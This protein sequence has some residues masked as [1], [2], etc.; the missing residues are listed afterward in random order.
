MQ[1]QTLNDLNKPRV[2]FGKKI[3]YAVGGA[4]DTLAY[5]FVAAFLLFFLTDFAGVNPAWAGAILTIGVIWD[6]IT[7]PIIGNLSDKTKTKFGRKRTWLIIAIVPLFVS[8][9][10]LFTKIDVMSEG[11]RN[12]YFLGMTLLFWLSYTFFSIPYYAIGASMTTDNT[13]RT[14]IRML[15]MIIQYIGVFFST[16]A[17][18]MFVSFFKAGGMDSYHAWHYTAWINACICVVSLIIVVIATKD[19]EID[20]EPE[21]EEKEKKSNLIKDCIAILKIKPYLISML[22]S[23]M[24]R[25]G[26]CFFLTTMT[27]FLLYVVALTEMKMTACTSIISFGGIIV[28][29]IL[30]KV[31]EKID[32]VKVY[33]VLLL[34]SGAGMVLFNFLDVNTMAMACLMACIYVVGSSAYWAINIP[35]M[36]DSIEVDEF[37]SGIR[38]EGTMMSFYLCCQKAGYAIAASIIGAVLTNS[39]YDETLGANNPQH[40]LDAIQNMTCLA[41]GIFFI[42]AAAIMFIYPLKQGVYDKL[43][44]QLENKRAGKEYNTEGFAHV[45]GKKFR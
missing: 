27:Y 13:E 7:D 33:A 11:A 42:L 18:T 37:Q 23:L 2:T 8:Y 29:A 20:F 28:I 9:L 21:Q 39:G 10:L 4:T 12:V 14:K 36:Y 26:Y 19:V 1:N 3:G 38:R 35:V 17:P 45:L 44:V 31:I 43:Y 30:M 41:T 25:V 6:M 16:V 22:G 5:D 34:I 40:V 24:F 32:K 15:G